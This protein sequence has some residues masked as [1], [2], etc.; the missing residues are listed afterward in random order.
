MKFAFTILLVLGS[1][2]ASAQEDFREKALLIAQQTPESKT[3]KIEDLA[4]FW[5]SQT[6]NKTQLCAISYAWIG[7]NIRYDVAQYKMGV[8]PASAEVLYRSA[9]R[10]RKAVCDGYANLFVALLKQM[11]IQAWVISGYTRKDNDVR[12]E[13]HSW[14]SVFDGQ[15]WRMFD[16]T[17]G[18]GYLQGDRYVASFNWLWY[19]G[20]PDDFLKTHMPFDVAWQC[21]NRMLLPSC[22]VSVSCNDSK[23]IS[24]A[25]ADTLQ[26]S[27]TDVEELRISRMLG[28]I[29]RYAVFNR[30]TQ[31]FYEVW[32]NN[33][34]VIR[35]NQQVEKLNAMSL[36]LNSINKTTQEASTNLNQYFAFKRK[37]KQRNNEAQLH[38]KNAETLMN[39][40][41]SDFSNLGEI[42][43]THAENGKKLKTFLLNMRDVIRKEF[44][45]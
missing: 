27:F 8:K 10:D 34:K 28:R 38:L 21:S 26:Q 18:A 43:P 31:S 36:S 5:M 17:W 20:N 44:A 6:Q 3:K 1:Y 33:L 30:T 2:W 14:A 11:N 19:S 41:L 15:N 16:P 7:L 32:E 29:K 23:R 37:G 24:F 35:Y 13:G 4:A 45:E 42:P 22:F 25:F 39:Q 12:D 9:L 40:A